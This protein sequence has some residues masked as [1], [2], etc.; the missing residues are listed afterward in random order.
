MFLLLNQGDIVVSSTGAQFKVMEML[1]AGGQGEVYRVTS[2]S[3]E[4]ALKWYINTQGTDEQREALEKLIR[5]GQP[6]S[7]F[8]WPVDLMTA[9]DR[10][11][12]GYIMPLRERRFKSIVDLMKG[13]IDPTFANL[14]TASFELVDSY[15]KL[16]A[17]GLCYK[18]ISF[19]NVFLDPGTGEIRICDNDNVRVD[20]QSL[21]AGVGGT[22]RFMAPEIVRGEARPSLNTDLFSLAVLVFYMFT[23]SHPLE[24]KRETAIHSF[25][26]P[27]M[28]KIYGDEPIFIFDPNDDTNR[29]DPTVHTCVEKYWSIYPDFIKALFI[30]SFTDGIRDPEN[31]R[32][33][34]GEWRAALLRLKDSIIFCG[35]CGCENFCEEGSEQICW[36]CKHPVSLP[37]RIQ[38]E[39]RTIMLNHDTYLNQHH[40]DGTSYDLKTKIATLSQNPK[41]PAIWGLKNCTDHDWI[42]TSVDGIRN[43][44][45]SGQ[46]IALKDGLVI[47]FGTIRGEIRYDS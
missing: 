25:D 34:E 31:G 23:I 37:P 46:S 35:H 6:T 7:K 14:V 39:D 33:R 26:A 45:G 27:A 47:D 15:K 29:P 22:P 28:K 40:L 8:L 44:I 1:G 20:K 12:F 43:S 2:D 9:P 32:V 24:G 4:W 17:E 42:A 16:H 19:G 36:N 21:N 41:N 5:N 18:D 38:I 3:S 10:P 13:R 30:R 11:G